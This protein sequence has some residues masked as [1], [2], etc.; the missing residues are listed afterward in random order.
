M[1][2]LWKS[3][4]SGEFRY[5]GWLA[6]RHLTGAEPPHPPADVGQREHQ[7]AAEPVDRPAAATPRE[8]RLAELGGGEA[9]GERSGAHPVPRR[10]REPE[11]VVAGGRL[12][13]PPLL[14]IRP[15]GRGL[16]RLPQIPG[17]EA[18]RI[19]Q[20]AQEP[21]L[22]GTAA[23]VGGRRLLVLEPDAVAVG[24]RLDRRGEVEV[25]GLAHERDVVAAPL[26]AEAVVDLL[27]R[28]DRE[29]GRALVVERAASDVPGARAAKRRAGADQVDHVDRDLQGLE[30]LPGD[31]AHA[32]EASALCAR[33]A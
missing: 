3:R 18:G 2:S 15:R 5:F 7:A 16:G 11:A 1:S 10:R 26:A 8:P 29:R 6:A 23:L 9:L 4:P 33:R 20:Q 25:L 13:D 31:R 19:V 24:Q 32:A 28:V 22:F 14:E 30:A 21:A 17:V 12:G 27:H